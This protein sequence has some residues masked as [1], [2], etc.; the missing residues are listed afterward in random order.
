MQ[1]GIT[2]TNGKKN[3]KKEAK[4]EKVVCPRGS[5]QIRGDPRTRVGGLEGGSRESVRISNFIS[6]AMPPSA[7][8]GWGGGFETLMRD[9]RTLEGVLL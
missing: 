7:K 1:K 5:A 8:D 4:S 3:P 9:R 2:K 6:Y